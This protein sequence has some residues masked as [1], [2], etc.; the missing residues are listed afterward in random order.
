MIYGHIAFAAAA[1][2]A[3]TVLGHMEMTKPC[4]RYTPHGNGCSLL[5]DGQSY[6]YSLSSPLASSAPLCKHTI[7]YNKPSE[8]WTAGKDITVSFYPN[9]G[10]GHRGGHCQ[11]SVSYDSGKTFAVVHEVLRYC[12]YNGPSTSNTPEVRSYTFALPEN[13]P[14]SDKVVFAWTWVNAAGNREFYM[15]CA[16]VAIKGSSSS[17]YT[18]KEM[19]IANHDGYPTIPEFGDNYDTGIKYYED[20]KNI[21]VSASGGSGGSAETGNSESASSDSSVNS[22]SNSASV[23]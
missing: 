4:S 13:L 19:V 6:D 22:A 11:W 20:A 8:T 3:T 1:A 7:P 18:G 10:V 21:T 16:D 9:S 17:H 23:S 15:N 12:F 14:S 2:L 5:P